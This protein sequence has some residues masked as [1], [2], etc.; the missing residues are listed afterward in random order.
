MGE[1]SCKGL[2]KLLQ[3][4]YN[5]GTTWLGH[6][7]RCKKKENPTWDGVALWSSDRPSTTILSD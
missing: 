7:V 3:E 1:Q 6:R 4:G 5:H 2:G